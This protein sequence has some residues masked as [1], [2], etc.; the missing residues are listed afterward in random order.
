MKLYKIIIIVAIILGLVGGGI[1]IGWKIAKPVKTQQKVTADVILTALHAR[2]FLVTEAIV[3]SEPIVIENTEG[4]VWKD[5]FFGQTIEARGNMEVN[6]GVDLKK[7]EAA[8]IIVDSDQVTVWLPRAEIFNS[9]LVGPIDVENKQGL[10]KRLFDNDDGYNQAL[11][12]MTK[13]AEAAA[14][15]LELLNKASQNAS[16]EVTRILQLIAKDKK[17]QINFKNDAEEES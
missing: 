4:S 15:T 13:Q 5:L 1:Y 12:E 17:I 16:D 3:F 8:D 2:G 9:R 14:G 6:L 11:A 7:V 10:L